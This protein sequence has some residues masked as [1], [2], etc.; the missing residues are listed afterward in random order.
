MGAI[1]MPESFTARKLLRGGVW[2][3]LG[4]LITGFSGVLISALLARL[5]EPGELAAYFL[6]FSLVTFTTIVVQLG[7]AQSIVRFVAESLATEQ[8]A[9]ARS[10][11]QKSLLLV[12][13]SYVVIGFV[14]L[15]GGWSWFAHYLAHSTA[16]ASVI[17][18]GIYWVLP[19][20]FQ[21]LLAEIFRGFNNIKLAT[22]FGG[23]ITSLLSLIAFVSLYW[24]SGHGVLSQIILFSALA[25]SGSVLLALPFL[26]IIIARLGKQGACITLNEIL[27]VSTPLWGSYLFLFVLSQADIWI[28]AMFR[29]QEE[30]AIYGAAA[31]LVLLIA[32]PLMVVNAVVP[33]IMARFYAQGK[34]QQLEKVLRNIATASGIPLVLII[35]VLI[36]FGSILLRMIFGEYYEAGALA[37]SLLC[38]GQIVNVWMG[39]PGLL[40]IQAG[41]QKILF[42]ITVCNGLVSL[43]L[44][45]WLVQ[46]AGYNGVATAT[47]LGVIVQNLAMWY[48]CLKVVGIDTRSYPPSEL[49]AIWAEYRHV[50]QLRAGKK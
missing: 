24:V 41:R 43:T 3:F 15:N 48:A 18:V 7:L 2:A 31:K 1:L 8:F 22:I 25:T 39:S 28:L 4:K 10:A 37:F 46:F 42:A 36:P 13:A 11:I 45:A 17:L 35:I 14:L 34:K 21:N 27:S 26:T 32:M 38:I 29:P 40:L 20:A 19:L 47:M 50:F 23:L 6:T 30:V 44:S 16:V 5:L 33:P 9:R 12:L 49:P